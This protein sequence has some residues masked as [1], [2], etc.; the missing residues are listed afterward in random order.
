LIGHDD[1]YTFWIRHLYGGVGGV[2]D[3]H[4]LQEKKSPEDAV[5]LDIPDSKEKNK[6]T[7][8]PEAAQN[9]LE[10]RTKP[11]RKTMLAKVAGAYSRMRPANH[12]K[13]RPE[14]HEKEIAGCCLA[15]AE[16]PTSDPTEKRRADGAQT[17]K[18]HRAGLKTGDWDLLREPKTGLRTRIGENSAYKK[19]EPRQKESR[20]VLQRQN[21]RE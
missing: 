17:R 20:R 8:F 4:K 16:R 5:V 3:C 18:P 1:D 15:R 21:A 9:P 6:S 19:N 14:S 11:K 2:D 12:G 7:R 13:R 10:L